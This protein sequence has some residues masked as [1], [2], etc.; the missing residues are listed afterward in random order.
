MSKGSRCSKMSGSSKRKKLHLRAL[1]CSAAYIVHRIRLR[2]RA[3]IKCFRFF[4]VCE[5]NGGDIVYSLSKYT[6]RKSCESQSSWTG[7]TEKAATYR[8]CSCHGSHDSGADGHRPDSPRALED[9]AAQCA[10]HNAVC[11]VVLSSVVPNGAVDTVVNHGY[12][13]G[14]VAKEGSSSRDGVQHAVES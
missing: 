7:K 9:G 3:S 12:D 11:H 1:P 5:W 6:L 4:F 2:S 14:R 13:T 10:C 8:P